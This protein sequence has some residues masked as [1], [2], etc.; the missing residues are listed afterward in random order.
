[1]NAR[2]KLCDGVGYPA[3]D[4]EYE[5]VDGRRVAVSGRCPHCGW[6]GRL[7][8]RAFTIFKHKEIPAADRMTRITIVPWDPDSDM[9]IVSHDGTVV[10]QDSLSSIDQYLRHSAPQGVPVILEVRDA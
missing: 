4:L 7:T 5:D 2:W 9:A 10:W 8:A 1:V 6:H 3:V